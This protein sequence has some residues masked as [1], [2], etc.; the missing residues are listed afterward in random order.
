MH[1]PPGSEQC[2]WAPGPSRDESLLERDQ[3]EVPQ[4]PVRVPAW[5]KLWPS[6]LVCF[7]CFLSLFT[8]AATG[9]HA[10]LHLS[11]DL[12]VFLPVLKSIAFISTHPILVPLPFSSACFLLH[13]P[14]STA[15]VPAAG[16]FLPHHLAAISSGLSLPWEPTPPHGGNHLSDHQR[17]QLRSQHDREL[18]WG[19]LIVSCL[20]AGLLE[21]MQSCKC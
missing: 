8:W 17:L 5:S 4:S 9:A 18:N 20:N 2:C 11:T 7:M 14:P 1:N 15:A 13:S 6:S 16:L 21:A 12:W 19:V 10:D 3:K